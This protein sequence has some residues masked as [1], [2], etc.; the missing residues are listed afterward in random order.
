MLNKSSFDMDKISFSREDLKRNIKIPKRIDRE[1]SE[2][3]GIIFGDGCLYNHSKE[4]WRTIIDISGDKDGDS[5]FHKNHISHLFQRKFGISLRVQDY[6]TWIQSR[7]QSKA[8][9]S[10]FTKVLGLKSGN[11]NDKLEIPEKF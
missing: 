6:D 1:I 10:Y 8:I 7:I 3:V 9:F 4:R 2:L 11:K 5:E